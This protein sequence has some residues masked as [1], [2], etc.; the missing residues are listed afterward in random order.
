MK[1]KSSVL[2]LLEMK[3]FHGFWLVDEAHVKIGSLKKRS[4]PV[5]WSRIAIAIRDIPIITA[6][7]TGTGD[8]M[9]S[10]NPQD[11]EAVVR[12]LVY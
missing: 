7:V 8:T 2:L 3:Y 9:Y 12:I 4:F 6:K 10:K 1:C 11:P 5:I